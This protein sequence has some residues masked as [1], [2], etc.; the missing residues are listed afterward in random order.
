M[1]KAAL[2]KKV[3][4]TQAAW[5][6]I[7]R[8]KRFADLPTAVRIEKATNGEIK[9]EQ[10]VRP[11]V[12]EALRKYLKLRCPTSKTSTHREKVKSDKKNEEVTVD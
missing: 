4:I 7:R 10:I 12:A 3:G 9:V 11:E 1:P 5:S 6:Q 2:Y 8:G